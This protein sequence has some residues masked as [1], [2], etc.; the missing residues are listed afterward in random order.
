MSGAPINNLG[1]VTS[2]SKTSSA[3]RRS[4]SIK[5]LSDSVTK[6]SMVREKRASI[7]LR[8]LQ[9]LK[10]ES[11]QYDSSPVVEIKQ[12]LQDRLMEITEKYVKIISSEKSRHEAQVGE[13]MMRIKEDEE[14]GMMNFNEEM[15]FSK[16]RLP[17]NK[18]FQKYSLELLN[19]IQGI[20]PIRIHPSKVSSYTQCN[21]DQVI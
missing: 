7:S 5:P 18:T 17:E 1:D 16:K 11:F 2:H 20:F 6:G 15:S 21:L 19:N 4:S 8:G 3:S 14:I 9:S 10:R 13:I 12:T